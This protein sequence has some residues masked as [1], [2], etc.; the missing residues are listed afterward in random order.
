MPA[1]RWEAMPRDLGKAYLKSGN[2]MWQG[3]GVKP[4]AT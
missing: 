3:M 4:F 1:G 2:G